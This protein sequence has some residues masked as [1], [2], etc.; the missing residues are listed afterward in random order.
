LVVPSTRR[1][2]G[3]PPLD[4]V[5]SGIAD[6][7]LARPAHTWITHVR[8]RV[9]DML[10]ERLVARGLVRRAGARQ[11]PLGHTHQFETVDLAHARFTRGHLRAVLAGAQPA[12]LRSAVLAGLL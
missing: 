2:T 1:P 5:L 7:G 3:D 6:T 9:P 8:A 11:G 12:S 10:A 4:T